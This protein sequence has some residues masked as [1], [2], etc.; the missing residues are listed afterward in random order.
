MGACRPFLVLLLVVGSAAAAGDEVTPVDPLLLDGRALHLSGLGLRVEAPADDWDWYGG[1]GLD[2]GRTYLCAQRNGPLRIVVTLG[3]GT[4]PFQLVEVM[5]LIREALEAGYQRQG[6]ALR[7]FTYDDPGFPGGLRYVATAAP[8]GRVEHL[9]GYV[10]SGTITVNI[11]AVLV[12]SDE[13]EELLRMVKSVRRRTPPAPEPVWKRRLLRAL[14][15]AFEGTLVVL[16]AWY[17]SRK[18]RRPTTLFG[19]DRAG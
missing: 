1:Q 17:I 5:A 14:L 19:D 8:E 16:L 7:S 13:P 4:E 6:A 10:L 12:S 18:R 11:Q 3:P 2:E 9:V 15:Y